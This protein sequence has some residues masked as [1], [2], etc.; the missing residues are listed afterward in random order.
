MKERGCSGRK[1]EWEKEV[2]NKEEGE[3]AA[4]CGIYAE[5]TDLIYIHVKCHHHHHHSIFVYICV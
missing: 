5:F 1:V 4:I 3:D 2:R